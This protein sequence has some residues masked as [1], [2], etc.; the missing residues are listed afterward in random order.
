[1]LLTLRQE[2][3][4]LLTVAAVVL[5]ATFLNMLY[6]NT[7]AAMEAA[8]C[9]ITGVA[10]TC[11]GRDCARRFCE[12]RFRSRCEKWLVSGRIS[13]AWGEYRRQGDDELAL[14][15]AKCLGYLGAS[16]GQT[17]SCWRPARACSEIYHARL[18]EDYTFTD[19]GPY[20]ELLGVL[21]LAVEVVAAGLVLLEWRG[22]VE[23][24]RATCRAAFCCFLCDDEPEPLHYRSPPPSEQ[25]YSHHQGYPPQGL[26]LG[27]GRRLSSGRRPSPGRPRRLR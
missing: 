20:V 4:P 25:Q 15:D 2:A 5:L 17:V 24:G 14:T 19:P 10:A 22:L 27:S 23:A 11:V 26:L 16:L 1:M 13:H 7:V 12:Y 6:R 18:D 21:V 8:N 9:E 3:R